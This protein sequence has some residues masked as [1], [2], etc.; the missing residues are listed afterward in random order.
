M[1]IDIL[2][3]GRFQPNDN[4]I[5]IA[6]PVL[7]IECEATPPLDNYLDAYEETVL[8]LVSIGLS[9]HGISVTLNATESLIE[10]ILDRLDQK[11]YVE[12]EIGKPWNITEDGEK[13]LNGTIEER[14]SNNSQFGYMFVNAIKKEVL[15]F[16]YQGDINQI[17][18]FRGAKLP[19]KLTIKGDEVKTFEDFSMKRTKLREAYKRYYKNADTSKQYSD[20][21]ITLDEAVDLF[22]G[23][24]YFDE[25]EEVNTL[26]VFDK[27]AQAALKENLFIRAL[28]CPPKHVYLTMRV[29]LDPQYPGG[30]RVESPF[31]LNGIDDNYY[32]RQVQWLEATG[33]TYVGD[34]E[35]DSF[36]TREIKKIC[37]TYKNADKDFSVFI[38]EKLPLL[39]IYNT[40]FLRI[41]DDMSRIYHLMKRQSSSND[42]ENERSLIDKEN[43]VNNIAR[44]VVESLFNEF[45]R[46]VKKETL[47]NISKKAINDLHRY[48][49]KSFKQ[50]VLQNTSLDHLKIHW[51]DNYTETVITRLSKTRGNSIVEKFINVIVLNYYLGTKETKRFLTD[52]N[53]QKI[54]DLTD[55]LN[56]IRRK[57]SHDTDER[58]EVRDY[59]FYMA[60]V[61]QLING[62]LEAYR[63][64]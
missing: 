39:K 19:A 41:Y 33:N 56:R 13:Y 36:L 10:E 64:D 37:P 2:S 20:G 12:K 22:Q 53:V 50:Y 14:E 48:K 47:L 44:Y 6:L 27:N 1:N 46:G 40:K 4:A 62:L 55:Q 30:Y 23:L 29:I 45:F 17:S 58:F 26:E 3:M 42:K 63:E 59:E 21:D 43:I 61:Y 31:D 15:P 57:V 28:N 7:S 8:K 32:L 54:Y 25:E 52:K 24:E 60:N 5:N 35:L 11:N 38:I 9:T 49:S 51:N 34:E 18:L 16:F